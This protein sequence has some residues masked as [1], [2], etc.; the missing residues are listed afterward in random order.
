MSDKIKNTD[1][2]LKRPLRRRDVLKRSLAGTAL[3]AGSSIFAPRILRAAGGSIT[4]GSFQDNAMVPFRD[5]FVKE[6]AS[7][8]GITVNYNE[9]NYDTWYQNCKNDGLNKTGAYDIYVMD[10]N[11]VPEFAAGKIVQS[12]DQLGLKANPDILPAGL[13]MGM[14]PPKSG[15]RMKDF[16]DAKPELYSLVIIDDVEILYYNKDHFPTPPVTWDDIYAVAKTTKAPDMYGWSPRGVKGNPIVQTYLP[17]LNSY[18]GNFV[19]DDWTPGFAGPEGVGALSRLFSFIPYMPDGVVEYDTDQEVQLMLEGKCTALTEYTGTA[20]RVD[21]PSSSKV[22]GKIYMAATPKQVKSGP[23][24]GTF[25]ASVSAGAKNP[26]GAVQF[27]EWFTSNDTQLE[28]ARKYGGAAVTG[29]ALN[30]PEAVQ[31]H[32]WLPAIADA[33]NNSVQKPRTPDE[34]KMEDILGTALNEALVEAIAAKANYDAISQK[35]LSAAADQITAYLK[36]QGGYF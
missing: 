14:W 24:I 1:K 18:G 17:L 6:F 22:V 33:V 35:H 9:T 10:D 31:K 30:D 29:T 26:E 11:W 7:K 19:N 4:I 8:T 27:L 13:N 25:I 12:L 2:L 21:D 16:A 36:Q 5:Y 28:F 15:P 23:A 20:Q 32:R 3:V 34:P